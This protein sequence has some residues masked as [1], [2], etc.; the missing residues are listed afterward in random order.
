M[1]LSEAADQCRQ[2]GL[3]GWE[4]I[5]FT[6]RLVAQTMR[7]SVENSL[8]SPQEAFQK[9][10]GY[11]W[12]QAKALHL[13]LGELA[14]DSRLVHAF[15]CLFPEA[16]LMGVTV[17][18]FVSGHV[19]CRVTVGG[20]EKDVC[21]GSPDNVPG[22]LHFTPLSKVREW[23]KAMDSSPITYGHSQPQPQEQIP[24]G[25]ARGTVI[26]QTDNIKTSRDWLVLSISYHVA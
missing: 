9:G 4:L 6:Q 16:V 13:L 12:H 8:D 22:R 19:W 18:R 1:T 10:Q 15:R 21:P 3:S 2:T 23:N 7:Y 11:C 5:Q 24:Q 25:N 14:I 17:H 20:E 26:Y